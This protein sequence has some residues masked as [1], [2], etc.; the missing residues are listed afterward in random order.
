MALATS[1][2]PPPAPL[3]SVP[4]QVGQPPPTPEKVEAVAPVLDEDMDTEDALLAEIA[5]P[6]LKSTPFNQLARKEAELVKQRAEIKKEQEI[7][8]QQREETAK[9]QAQWN[10]FNALKA[11]N[12]VEAF[13][14]LG[15]SET[16]FFNFMA[17]NPKPAEPTLEEKA[18]A[19]ASKAADERIKAYED[20]QAAK[21]KED[22]NK[23]DQTLIETFKSSL[24]ETVKANQE[25][26]EY[27]SHYGAVAEDLAYEYVCAVIAESK[28]TEMPTAEEAL[29][30][31]EE[32]YEEQDKAM[33]TIKKRQPKADP[34]VKAPEAAPTSVVPQRTRT[35]TAADPS[36]PPP[37]PVITRSRTLSSGN[38]ATIS[39]AKPKGPESPAQ[40]RERLEQWLRTGVKP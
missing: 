12:P 11:T 36:A 23:H 3:A 39:S 18:A 40:K 29:Q 37:N 9:A 8:A 7:L 16:D 2:Q 28:G 35:V 4:P 1:N 27:C 33:M 24:G 26:Y 30:A 34:E 38:T 13:K 20:Q 10:E 25:K 17:E 6:A 22:Q 14:K 32:Y 31:I 15:F 19:A 21:I 5:P